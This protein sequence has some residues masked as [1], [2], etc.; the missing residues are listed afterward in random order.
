MMHLYR[1]T[2]WA[3]GL[4]MLAL[5]APGARAQ[6]QDQGQQPQQSQEQ[7]TPPIAAYHSP[8]A[9][10]A[11][12]GDADGMN[13]DPQ[14]MIPDDR[15][16]AGAENLGLGMPSLTH[17]YWQPHF[18]LLSSLDSNPTIG[19]GESGWAAEASFTGGVDLHRTSGNSDMTVNYLGGGTFSNNGNVS[20]GIVQSLDFKDKFTFRRGSIA[21]FDQL[22]YLPGSSFGFS[23]LGGVTLP[24]SGLS[25]LGTTF[26]PSESILTPIGQNLSNSF[27]T[28]VDANL[29]GR[30]TISLVAGYSLL[31]YFDGGL[32]DSGDVNGQIGYNYQLNRTDTIALSY[33]F[34]AIRYSNFDQSINSNTVFVSYARRLTGRLAF[35]VSAGPE[36]AF[37]KTPIT[38]NT[39]TTGDGGTS[40]SGTGIA[41]TNS[42]TLATWSVNTN[43]HYQLQRGNLGLS[44][45]HGVSGGS[46]VLAGSV[47]DT[48]SGSF[49]RPLTRTTSGSFNFGYAHNN[50]LS[51][52]SSTSAPTDQAYGYWFGSVNLNRPLGRTMNLSLTY[53]TQYQD[54][55]SSFC[56]GPT[57]GTSVVRQTVTVGLGWHAR[58]IAFE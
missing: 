42:T 36:F 16:L 24:G 44:Y 46:G 53:Q 34:S 17:S 35:Q 49:N 48:F 9:G 37:L 4:M 15:A 13:A 3:A 27:V 51:L 52:T 47:A 50:G 39:G 7:A 45:S 5:S 25:G 22:N 40:G 28:E 29:T 21:F 56:I 19:P 1:N 30:S 14:K 18:D 58:P 41:G 57:C 38:G 12:N 20:N 43:L 6:Q 54:S 2:S 10:A 55:N 26:T 11:D 23:G 31:H 33:Q 8:L 32:L